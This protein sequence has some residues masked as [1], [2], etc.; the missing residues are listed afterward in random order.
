MS[1]VPMRDYQDPANW[2][3]AANIFPL[4]E[5][6]EL[7]ALVADIRAKGLLNDIVLHDDLLLGFP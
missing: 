1:G 6:E 4:I 7:D 2:H 5:G 3:P